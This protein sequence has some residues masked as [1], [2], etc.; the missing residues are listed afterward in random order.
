MPWDFA[1]EL[2]LHGPGRHPRPPARG[3]AFAYC[4]RV[5]R[6]HYEN[7]SVVSMLL[8][9]RLLRHFHAVYAYC[10]WADD[11]ADETLGDALP[12]LGWWRDELDACFAGRPRHPVFVAL[13]ETV[14]AFGLPRRPFLDLLSAF[15]QDQTVKRYDTFAQLLDYCSR[16][17]DP[18]GRL[19]LCLFRCHD[20]ARAAL[21]DDVCTALQ[22]TNFWQDVARDLRIGRVYLPAEDRRRFGYGDDDLLAGRFT[23]AFA[24]LLAFEVRRTRGLF[25]RGAALVAEVP[26]EL[27]GQVEL[28]I[29][30]GL[31]VLA[32]V[33]ARGYDVWSARP[34]LPGWQKGRLLLGVLWRRAREGRWF[35]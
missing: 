14:A 19:V 24:E 7:F 30:G 6:G 31:A 13:R 29:E 35:A 4:A 27:R 20:P 12:L 21:S 17:A 8:P 33:E 28:F 10:R 32:R 18:V 16:S 15:E 3:D 9:R 1:R 34:A 23:P 5:A 2:A 11:L 26:V 22:L 25:A